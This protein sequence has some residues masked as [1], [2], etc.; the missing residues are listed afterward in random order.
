MSIAVQPQTF[1]KVSNLLVPGA[2]ANTA[3]ATSAWVDIG[4]WDGPIMVVMQIGTV[5]AGNIAGVVKHSPNS[6]GSGSSTAYTFTTATAAGSQIA[7][8]ESGSLGRYLN[9]TGTITTGPVDAAVLLIGRDQ[10]A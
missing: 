2:K 8:L 6:D 5:T 10:Y 1:N 3:A 4:N 9:F 7:V